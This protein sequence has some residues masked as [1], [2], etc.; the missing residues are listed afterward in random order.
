MI[1]LAILIFDDVEVLDFSGPYEVFSVTKNDEEKEVFNVFNVAE[2]ED[3][4]KARNGYLVKPNYSLASCPRPEILLIPGG[5]GTRKEMHNVHLIDW[6]KQMSG[7]CKLVLSVCTG[8][9]LLAKAGLLDG[10]EATTHH[11]ALDL[12][13]KTGLQTKVVSNRKFVDNGTVITSA[14]ISAG[15]EMS[16]H[17]VLK[18]LGSETASRTAKYMEYDCWENLAKEN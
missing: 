15:I 6:I 18:L 11:G 9:L 2:S 1:N 12:L 14:G 13:A 5:Y 7:E 3:I 8:S 4:V 16:L 10:L 17:V